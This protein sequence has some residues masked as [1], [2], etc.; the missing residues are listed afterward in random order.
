M[1]REAQPPPE[2]FD[3]LST[4]LKGAQPRP[5]DELLWGDGKWVN[6]P[7]WEVGLESGTLTDGAAN[8]FR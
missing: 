1:R 4:S 5:V 2:I 7:H 8:A 3:M 6:W